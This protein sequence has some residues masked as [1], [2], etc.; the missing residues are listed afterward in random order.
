MIANNLQYTQSYDPW[1]VWAEAKKRGASDSTGW[2]IQAALQLIKDMK[3]SSGYVKIGDSRNA[4]VYTL[5]YWLS[6]NKCIVTGSSYGDW[7]K[8]VETGIYSESKKQA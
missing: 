8:I 2:I 5:K 6:T 1:T 7:G 4:D 3:H